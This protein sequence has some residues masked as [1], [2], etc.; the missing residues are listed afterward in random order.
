MR[1]HSEVSSDAIEIFVH[2]DCACARSKSTPRA[3][4]RASSGVV[5]GENP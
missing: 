5:S 4:Q 3:A 2:D 1:G